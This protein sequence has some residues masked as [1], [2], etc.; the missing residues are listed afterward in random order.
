[1]KPMGKDGLYKAAVNVRRE[2]GQNLSKNIL[3]A[4]MPKEDKESIEELIK[5]GKI[6]EVQ[7]QHNIGT[8]W[9][10]NDGGY[11]VECDYDSP[12]VLDFIRYFLSKE[13]YVSSDLIEDN[14]EAYNKWL[15][16]N[17]ESLEILKNSK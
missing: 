7:D 13:K 8:W 5:E 15:E 9:C 2:S 14:K 1:M 10:P 4:H 17:R 16:K 12:Y 11:N 3:M 6:L